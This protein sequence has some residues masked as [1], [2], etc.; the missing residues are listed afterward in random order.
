METG[1]IHLARSAGRARFPARFQLLAAMNP[2]PAG[3]ICSSRSCRCRPD[4]VQRYRSRVSG[5][6]LDRID[7]HVALEPVP[8]ELLIGSGAAGSRTED[9]GTENS[10]MDGTTEAATEAEEVASQA[11]LA[12]G[13]RALQLARA[14]KPNADLDARELERFVRLGPS[15]RALLLAAADRYQLSA[16][17]IHRVLRVARTVA[18]LSGEAEEDSVS[19]EALAEALG[20]RSLD[21][22]APV[23]TGY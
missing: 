16:R 13:A 3:L 5:P 14:G 10:R 17:G 8:G 9:S 4:Q 1:E 19:P 2:C 21:W 6:L 7:L 22:S 20:F 18:D 23:G 11:T 15:E 12:A